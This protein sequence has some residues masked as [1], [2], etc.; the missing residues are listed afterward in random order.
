[1]EGHVIPGG[2]NV[3]D[4]LGLDGAYI[5]KAK[6]ALRIQKTI[7]EMGL[8]QRQAVARMPITQ[9]KLSLLMRG[10]LDWKGGEHPL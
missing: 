5:I 1:M 4:D 3:L 10:K 7:A 9:P 6:L 2:K 8:T